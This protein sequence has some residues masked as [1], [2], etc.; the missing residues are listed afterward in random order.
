MVIIIL[1]EDNALTL[2][3]ISQTVTNLSFIIILIFLFIYN[4]VA[5]FVVFSRILYAYALTTYI[6]LINIIIWYHA[7]AAMKQETRGSPKQK[8]ELMLCETTTQKAQKL[9][10]AVRP[11]YIHFMQCIEH[12]RV[13][14]QSVCMLYRKLS[15][16]EM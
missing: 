7:Q 4:F 12:H 6:I 10:I 15:E 3:L 9:A 14:K 8:K 11:F 1:K 5:I 16:L 2:G 13:N